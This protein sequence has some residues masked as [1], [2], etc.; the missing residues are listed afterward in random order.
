MTARLATLK[1]IANNAE[2]DGPIYEKWQ[3]VL[4]PL[5]ADLNKALGKTMGRLGNPTR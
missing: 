2:I 1:S 5:R 4:E 3:A